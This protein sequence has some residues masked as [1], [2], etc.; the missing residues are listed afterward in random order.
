MKTKPKHRLQGNTYILLASSKNIAYL[1]EKHTHCQVWHNY[2][3]NSIFLTPTTENELLV[4]FNTLKSS[5]CPG[6][7]GID[8]KILK[9]IAPTIIQ[10]LLFN[11]SLTDGIVPSELKIAKVTPIF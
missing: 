4:I 2:D 6:Y 8:S 5:S 1:K 11:K 10:T 9:Q 3:K 7:D